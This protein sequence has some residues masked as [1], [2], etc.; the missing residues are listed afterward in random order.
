[1]WKTWWLH[2]AG[3]TSRQFK[4]GGGQVEVFGNEPPPLPDPPEDD[5]WRCENFLTGML[6]GDLGVLV[7]CRL[8]GGISSS[9]KRRKKCN[10][11]QPGVVP[12]ELGVSTP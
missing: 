6:D 7:G 9:S 1:M 11:C 2:A 3:Q 8:P 4:A 12:S 10:P 5:P